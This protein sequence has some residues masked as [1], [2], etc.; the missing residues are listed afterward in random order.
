M[1]G[2]SWRM[3]VAVL[4]VACG[5]LVVGC[6]EPID[7]D[8]GA[9]ADDGEAIDDEAAFIERGREDP[10]EIEARAGGSCAGSCG[11]QSPDGCWCDSACANYG[12]CCADKVQVCDGAPPPPPPPPTS[13]D[14]PNNTYCADVATWP[15]AATDFEAQVVTLVNQRRAAGATCGSYG[16]FAPAGPLTM[17]P[18]LRCAARKHDKDMIANNFFSHTGTGGTTPWDRIASAG[19]GTYKTAGENIAA[20]QTTPSAVVTGW[21]NSPGHCKNIM[22]AGFKE[23]G[24]GYATG[25]SYGHYW[26]QTFAAKP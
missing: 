17:N 5:G 6:D 24:V 15:A 25:G 12:D 8:D 11:G 14:V 2:D 19:Y 7:E 20:G 9:I 10:D 18:A 22:A 1:V 4:G 21:M 23:I 13:G 3:W 16:A 26:T